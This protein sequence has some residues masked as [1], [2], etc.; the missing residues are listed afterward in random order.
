MAYGIFGITP[1]VHIAPI[2]GASDFEFPQARALIPQHFHYLHYDLYCELTVNW[3]LKLEHMVKIKLLVSN[4]PCI[5]PNSAM[6][7]YFAGILPWIAN[8]ADSAHE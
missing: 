8:R 3:A 7:Y 2:F 6:S 4:Y 5:I 1:H